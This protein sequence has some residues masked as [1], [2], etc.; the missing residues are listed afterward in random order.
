MLKCVSKVKFYYLMMLLILPWVFFSANAIEEE[1]YLYLF[2]ALE[3]YQDEKISR[4]FLRLNK[5]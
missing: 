1:D 5:L 4:L 2:D 3:N